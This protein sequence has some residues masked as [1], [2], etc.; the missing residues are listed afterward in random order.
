MGLAMA[1]LE[2]EEDKLFYRRDF[3]S[4]QALALAPNT[5]SL[6]SNLVSDAT[7]AVRAAGAR[8]ASSAFFRLQS[9]TK[10]AN[11]S[12]RIGIFRVNTQNRFESRDLRLQH[13]DTDGVLLAF[14]FLQPGAVFVGVQQMLLVE[15]GCDFFRDLQLSECRAA[16]DAGAVH[17]EIGLEFR[18]LQSGI[19]SAVIALVR[20]GQGGHGEN[21]NAR[22][23]SEKP[24]RFH[25]EHPTCARDIMD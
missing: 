18:I 22:D 4:E 12:Q 25:R 7:T 13:V 5:E 17:V 20:P 8:L 9:G 14:N 1:E 3:P 23:W 15:T 11:R 10:F 19:G 2:P 21:K 6:V 24:K 16:F